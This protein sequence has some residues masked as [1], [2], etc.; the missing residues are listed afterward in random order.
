MYKDVQVSCSRTHRVAC[1]WQL[2]K[3]NAE[4]H[5]VAAMPPTPP[6]CCCCCR[7]RCR[8]RH[9]GH[10]VAEP[11]VVPM[12]GLNLVQPLPRR[13]AAAAAAVVAAA[14]PVVASGAAPACAQGT[15][16][17]SAAAP[18]KPMRRC[19]YR[20]HHLAAMHC[21]VSLPLLRLLLRQPAASLQPGLLLLRR[22]MR[23]PQRAAVRLPF[24]GGW[25]GE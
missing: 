12:A 24:T 2:N 10:A 21:A 19:R 23:C 25:A 8:R 17:G 5:L 13:A 16:A 11:R 1:K 15:A 4:S 6:C 20:R 3:K 22:A 9:R 7:S 18:P 14:A